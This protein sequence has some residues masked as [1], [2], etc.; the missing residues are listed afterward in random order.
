MPRG[1]DTSSNQEGVLYTNS[2]YE[3]ITIMRLYT[4]KKYKTREHKSSLWNVDFTEE[5]ML[6]LTHKV[7]HK[8]AVRIGTKEI[9]FKL[10]KK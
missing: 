4:K 7:Q 5:V 3:I 10:H 9:R 2:H 8:V 6:D 1:N